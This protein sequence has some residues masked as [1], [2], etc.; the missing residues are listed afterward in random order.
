MVKGMEHVA[1]FANDTKTLTDWYKEMFGLREVYNNGKGTIFLAFES[2]D[3]IEFCMAAAPKQ[4]ATDKTAGIR[5][6]ALAID[7]DKFDAMVEKLKAANVTVIADVAV[8]PKGI[9]TFFFA[10][11]EGN[12]SHLIYRP[13]PLV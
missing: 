2:G 11:P 3:M 6:L 13:E 9:K 5:H 7:D 12:I 10:D 8:S 4:D 1:V